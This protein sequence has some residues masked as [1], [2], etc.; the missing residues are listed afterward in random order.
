MSRRR[1]LSVLAA[2]AGAA[3][4][5]V[6][7][8]AAHPGRVLALARRTELPA[9]GLAF[10]W[11]TL[12]LACRGVRLGLL[13]GG[14]LPILRATAVIAA[15]QLPTTV[16]PMRMGELA[17]FPAL[18]AAGVAGAVR[19]LSFLVLTRVLDVGGLLAWAV[20]V[21]IWMRVPG[22]LTAATVAALAALAGYLTLRATR[23]AR[24]LALHLRRGGSWRRRVLRQLLEVRHELLKVS[25]S[26]WRAVS[27]VACSLATWGGI[28]QLTVVLLRGMGLEWPPD[29]ILL[30][31]IGAALGASLPL[32][33]V[34]TFGTQE[35][36]WAAA[37]ATV[38]VPAKAA[39]A[40]GFASHS[41]SV[42]FAA[43]HCL[44]A[45]PFLLAWHRRERLLG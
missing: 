15:A 33:A 30:G 31:M 37:L 8:W 9:L 10:A 7:L 2:V 28:W 16:L 11:A 23:S 26:P 41:W 19:G 32:N 45:L 4:L 3:L 6:L 39:L 24:R 12:V 34:G 25:H 14:R 42:A 21:G 18:R 44:V 17:F 29:S 5:A 1:L 27:V 35:A 13:S 20:G 38:G 43:I 22:L 36:G 40:A